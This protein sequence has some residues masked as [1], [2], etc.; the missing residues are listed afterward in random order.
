[1]AF[2]SSHPAYGN[3]SSTRPMMPN[4]AAAAAVVDPYAAYMHPRAGSF[5]SRAGNMATYGSLQ[6]VAD[7]EDDEDEDA[8]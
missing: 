8:F 4:P 7:E 6:D 5:T 2:G 1:M 3:S